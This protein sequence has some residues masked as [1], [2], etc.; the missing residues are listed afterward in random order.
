MACSREKA[1]IV[2]PAAVP[3]RRAPSADARAFRFVVC[4]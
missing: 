3:Q 1:H 2:F 4:L